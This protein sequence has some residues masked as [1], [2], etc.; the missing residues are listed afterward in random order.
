MSSK[1]NLWLSH[2]KL[3]WKQIYGVKYFIILDETWST[4][5][6]RV[7]SNYCNL[8]W[9]YSIN[10]NYY[11]QQLFLIKLSEHGSKIFFT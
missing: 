1:P 10:D 8:Y 2:Q 11:R 7:I 3:F 6:Q 5:N 4:K 9:T